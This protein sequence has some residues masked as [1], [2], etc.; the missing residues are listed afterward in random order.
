[1]EKYLSISE[2]AVIHNIS[3]QTLIYY[4]RIELFKP[5]NI[6][7]NGYRYYSPSQIPILR[8][9]CFLKSIG[10]KLEYI[11]KHIDNRDTTTVISMLQYHKNF[12]DKE[13]DSL[14]NIRESI[15]QR[16]NLYTNAHQFKDELYKPTIEKFAER[17]VIFFPF[18]KE[19]CKH[20]LHL[21][22][23]KAW[24]TLT[25]YGM[26]PAN[27]F[28]T[29]INKDKIHKNNIFEDA[30]IFLSLPFSHSNIENVI[31]LRE[32]EYACM[33]KYGMPYDTEPLYMLLHWINENGFKI[34][35]NIID[36]CLLD[37][38]FYKDDKN[39]DFCQIQIP[40]ENID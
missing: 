4:D 32:G 30:G 8:E 33:Y 34:A 28:G 10:I 36:T 35:G 27:G 12:I 20:E 29:I 37:T 22:L 2:M 5:I 9:I 6:D 38:T 7:I 24:N 23:M 16:L 25:K 18:E 40:I 21:T 15:E 19:V 14:L 31:N 17:K 26:L 11:K 39:L 13:I 1:M 3:R